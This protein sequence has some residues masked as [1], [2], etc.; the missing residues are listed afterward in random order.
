[1]NST[2]FWR[3]LI[4][5]SAYLL[6]VKMFICE[7]CGNIQKDPPVV[8][9]AIT[10]DEVAEIQKQWGESLVNIGKVFSAGGDYRKAALRHIE[11]FY[12]YDSGIVLFKPTMAEKKQ[13][14]TD[15]TSALSYFIGDCDDCPEDHGF[16][17]KKWKAVR[18]ENVGTK[19]KE[20][21]ALAMGNY[22]FTPD[23]DTIE[24]KVEYSFA[25]MKDK[26]G[27]LRIILHDSHIPYHH[28]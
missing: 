13:F 4:T 8:N 22:Y 17:L 26:K 14:R 7:K 27:Q 19:V 28:E 15:K 21:I 3:P 9:D 18:W 16:A 1:M 5:T 10:A 2:T 23:D 11:K 6:G 24:V 20:N 12:A 25:Y